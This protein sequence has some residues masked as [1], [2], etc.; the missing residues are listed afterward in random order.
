MSTLSPPLVQ[1][2]VNDSLQSFFDHELR[3]SSDTGPTS[4]EITRLRKSNMRLLAE[5]SALH[6][7]VSDFDTARAKANQLQSLALEL[8][9]PVWL[10]F[11]LY[12]EANVSRSMGW[13]ETSLALGTEA[14][15]YGREYGNATLESR[16]WMTLGKTSH[17]LGKI[18]D[19]EKAYWASW[20]MGIRCD[21]KFIQAHAMDGVAMLDHTYG[22]SN[23]A[24]KKLEHAIEYH[25]AI[26]DF[27]GLTMA[28]NNYITILLDNESYYFSLDPLARTIRLRSYL[29]DEGGVAATCALAALSLYQLGATQKA[30]RTYSDARAYAQQ[31]DYKFNM[32][33]TRLISRLLSLVRPD[34]LRTSPDVVSGKHLAE[35]TIKFIEETL[36]EP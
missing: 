11:G 13:Q 30:I 4:Q 33:E 35:R 5:G 18:D 16:A 28:N 23:A 15:R 34:D 3:H 8:G 14:L 26:K 10:G 20:R 31:L 2:K 17:R 27:H 7:K 32:S 6:W 19:T 22:D 29:Q 12:S 9:D 24:K 36:C 1:L 21:D 25:R